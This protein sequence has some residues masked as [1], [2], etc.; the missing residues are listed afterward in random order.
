MDGVLRKG[1]SGMAVSLRAK[2]IGSLEIKQESI[3]KT[4]VGSHGFHIEMYFKNIYVSM[5]GP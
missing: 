1:K 2:K 4:N 3:I 5:I